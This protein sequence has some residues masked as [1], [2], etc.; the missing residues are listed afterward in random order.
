IIKS[1]A[2]DPAERY[3]RAK[4]LGEDLARALTGESRSMSG[5]TGSIAPPMPSPLTSESPG[6]GTVATHNARTEVGAELAAR[7]AADSQAKSSSAVADV[8]PKPPIAKY[9]VGGVIAVAV[10]ALAIWLAGAGGKKNDPPPQPPAVVRQ[11][12]ISSRVQQKGKPPLDVP[13]DI[14]FNPGDSLRLT[15]NSSQEGFLYIVNESPKTQNGLPVYN[16]LFPD[17]RVPNGGISVKPGR[18]LSLPSEN[19]PW[20]PIDTEAGTETLWLIWSDHSINELEAAKKWLNEKDGGE[21]KDVNE[22][23]AVQQFI[24]KYFLEAKPKVEQE[25]SQK[26]LKGGKDGLLVY[27]MKLEHTT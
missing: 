1:M 7:L 17:G 8:Q 22:I 25:D 9:A 26:V 27:Q 24:D 11:L 19:P 21:I 10:I 4:D 12:S 3:Q 16:F 14:I 6:Y 15:F 5:A 13:G 20:W 2:F 23:R 18:P